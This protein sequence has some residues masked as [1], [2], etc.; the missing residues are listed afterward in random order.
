LIKLISVVDYVY[1]VGGSNPGDCYSEQFIN[2][3]YLQL[4]ALKR[5]WKPSLAKETKAK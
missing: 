2:P 4:L 3:E 5:H 1:S